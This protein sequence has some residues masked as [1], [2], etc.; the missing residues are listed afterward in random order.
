M[1]RLIIGDIHGCYSELQ[2]LIKKADLT[3]QDEIIALGDIVDRGPESPEVLSFFK[4]PI[5]LGVF[6]CARFP[7]EMAGGIHWTGKRNHAQIY[8]A[9]TL[10]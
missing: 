3:S 10:Y 9:Q 4:N 6:F 8:C 2:D 7:R 5:L 1:K